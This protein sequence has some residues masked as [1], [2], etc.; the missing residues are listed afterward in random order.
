MAT[1]AGSKLVLLLITVEGVGGATSR[2]DNCG[3]RRAS[4]HIQR[5]AIEADSVAPVRRRNGQDILSRC[6]CLFN[7]GV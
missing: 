6:D 3:L 4:D 5:Q 7:A 2:A 1:N